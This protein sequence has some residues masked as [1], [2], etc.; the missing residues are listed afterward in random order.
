MWHVMQ[1]QELQQ[2]AGEEEEENVCISKDTM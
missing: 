2:K 1:C